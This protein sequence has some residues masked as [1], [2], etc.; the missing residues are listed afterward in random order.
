[1]FFLLLFSLL[2]PVMIM[3]APPLSL[4]NARGW[5]LAFYI[6]ER[7]LDLHDL[8]S[9]SHL[10]DDVIHSNSHIFFSSF[11]SSFFKLSIS[12]SISFWGTLSCK[13]PTGEESLLGLYSSSIYA[14]TIYL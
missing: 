13:L 4:A 3:L 1:M 5:F 11:L 7:G 10:K 14:H 12:F 2:M 8:T 6:L 9:V